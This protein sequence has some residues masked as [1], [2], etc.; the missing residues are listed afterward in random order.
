MTDG[1]R[2]GTGKGGG[3]G[4]REEDMQ[5]LQ[6]LVRLVQS[7]RPSSLGRTHICVTEPLLKYLAEATQTSD[8]KPTAQQA[9]F[10]ATRSY[11]CTTEVTC[12]SWKA[13]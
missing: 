3:G 6:K 1:A 4:R 7:T 2:K 11:E 12:R 5:K 10:R 9:I 13:Q 8:D